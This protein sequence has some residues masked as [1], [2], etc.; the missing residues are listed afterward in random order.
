MYTTDKKETEKIIEEINGYLKESD[1]HCEVLNICKL[2][3][4]AEF[5][6]DVYEIQIEEE[7]EGGVK[8]SNLY[9][10]TCPFATNAYETNEFTF[11]KARS[12]HIEDGVCHALI[13]NR[14][15]PKEILNVKKLKPYLKELKKGLKLSVPTKLN[16]EQRSKLQFF[17]KEI[18]RYKIMKK[19]ES[20]KL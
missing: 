9:F 15:I 18:E 4:F 17:I 2:K 7:D 20:I 16:F 1:I 19:E 5:E 10:F 14:K 12:A 13:F 6:T 11:K 3:K 8:E